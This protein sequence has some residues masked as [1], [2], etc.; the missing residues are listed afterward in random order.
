MCT[1]TRITVKA[2]KKSAQGGTPDRFL[3]LWSKNY[4]SASYQIEIIDKI[5]TKE[6][7]PALL[8][9]VRRCPGNRTPLIAKKNR[10]P[11]EAGNAILKKEETGQ[12][13]I[14][15][16]SLTFR[17]SAYWILRSSQP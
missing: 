11:E 4:L 12:R 14:A 10:I 8:G 9:F 6:S 7:Y 17:Q 15:G 5:A 3:L 1:R 13:K 2:K 16:R